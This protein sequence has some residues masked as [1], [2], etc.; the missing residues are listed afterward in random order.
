MQLNLKNPIVF[1][2]LETTGINI[3][4]DRIVEISLLK[5]NVDGS[6]QSKTYRINPEM[7]IPKK[8]SEIH[9]IYDED[10][11]DAPT[12]KEVARQL[13]NFMEGCD[14]A[15]YN[16]NKFDIPLLAE[17]FIRAGVDFDMTKRKFIDVQ[18]IFHKMEK[19][20]LEAAY[21]FYCDK[22]LKDAHSAEADTRA[23]YEVLKAQLDRYKELK[24]DVEWLSKFS[25][26]NRNAD[27]VGRIIFDENGDE[28]FNF[29]KYKGQ[30][31][32]E[33]LKKD[34]GYYSWMM[35]GDFPLF[36]KKV[37]TNIKLR[38]AFKKE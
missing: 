14:I 22:T 20:T 1:F 6:E 7:P 8:S 27:F 16:S 34:P 28:V 37:L 11:A 36:T 33:V 21:K 9:G 2:D 3:A 13:A 12:F 35:N 31:V 15:G 18:T 5:V 29:G 25:S 17:E 30:K 19:R 23:T 26:H 10:V 4:K 24:N 38:S 32:T